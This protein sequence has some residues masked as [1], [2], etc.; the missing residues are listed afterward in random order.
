MKTK[1]IVASVLTALMLT[2]VAVV[3]VAA[4]ETSVNV[5]WGGSGIIGGNVN[6]GDDSSISWIATGDYIAGSFKATD[7]NNNSYS[8]GVDSVNSYMVSEVANGLS[9][10]LVTRD[11]AKESMYGSAGQTS[12]S[13]IEAVGGTAEFAM[14]SSTNYAS[15]KNPTYGKPKTSSGK[16]FEANASVFVLRQWVGNGDPTSSELPSDWATFNVVGSGTALVDVMSSEAR[17]G[18]IKLGHGCGCYTNAD[19]QL[20]GSGMAS[21]EAVGANGASGFGLNVPG[22]GSLQS[23]SLSVVAD[24]AGDFSIPDF[25]MTST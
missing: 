11:D 6:A 19:M 18:Q 12:L 16:N 4:D 15:M 20:S 7:H 14:G 3:P 24:Y 9:Q 2:L 25:S 1:R 13:Y 10:Y 8:Y 23:A 21:F 22:D 17:E 5:D